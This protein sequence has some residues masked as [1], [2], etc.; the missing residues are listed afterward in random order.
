MFNHC[1]TCVTWDRENFSTQHA[2][3]KHE[4]DKPSKVH[5][6]EKVSL[7]SIIIYLIYSYKLGN[8]GVCEQPVS[9]LDLTGHSLPV[10]E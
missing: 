2:C 7:S 4:V 10:G 8:T 3:S 6:Q 1:Y 5:P 9:I